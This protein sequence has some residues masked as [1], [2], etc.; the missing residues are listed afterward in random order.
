MPG[1]CVQRPAPTLTS[2]RPG[3]R[4]G[5]DPEPSLLARIGSTASRCA[6]GVPL[7]P[8]QGRCLA[9]E[10]GR[11]MWLHSAILVGATARATMSPSVFGRSGRV[12]TADQVG[13]G[14]RLETRSTRRVTALRQPG[15]T[16][17]GCRCATRRDRKGSRRE[18][19]TGEPA[20]N[21][22]YRRPVL[23]SHRESHRLGVAA[24]RTPHD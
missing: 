11:H 12:R 23:A 19:P 4:A 17:S 24:A 16:A 5:A 3:A 18:R 7:P 21:H 6:T 14:A 2:A 8:Q 22:R 20:Q 9:R 15:A 13:Q 1:P 10:I